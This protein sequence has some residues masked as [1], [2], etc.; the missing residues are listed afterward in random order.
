L[1]FE[2]RDKGVASKS[3]KTIPRWILLKQ[4]ECMI[5]TIQCQQKNVFIIAGERSNLFI[6]IKRAEF[7]IFQNFYEPTSNARFYVTYSS[8]VV[9]A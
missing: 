1:N 6:N 3:F 4:R 2:T 7:A 5:S 8:L 9:T